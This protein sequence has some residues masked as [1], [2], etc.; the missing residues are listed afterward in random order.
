VIEAQVETDADT[1]PLA[2]GSRRSHRPVFGH[3]MA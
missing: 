3:D 2:G 1:L